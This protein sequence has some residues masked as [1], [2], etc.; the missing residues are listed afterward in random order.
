MDR[1]NRYFTRALGPRYAPFRALSIGKTPTDDR[2]IQLEGTRELASHA[3]S[4]EVAERLRSRMEQALETVG[5]RDEA[6]PLGVS[7][8]YA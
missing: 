4:L 5:K 7:W 8:E 3:E 1:S 6:L 2:I